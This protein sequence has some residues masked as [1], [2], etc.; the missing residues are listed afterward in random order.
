M[1]S[2]RITRVR[3]I[4]SHGLEREMGVQGCLLG[5]IMAILSDEASSVS[6]VSRINPKSLI[7]T[8]FVAVSEV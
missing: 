4:S 2:A 1:R 8:L 5:T 6:D 3:M 7:F